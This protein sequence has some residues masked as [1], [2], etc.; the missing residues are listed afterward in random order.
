MSVSG[1]C[2][3]L[4]AQPRGPLNARPRKVRDG[5]NEKWRMETPFGRAKT[6]TPRPSPTHSPRPSERGPRRLGTNPAVVGLGERP[7]DPLGGVG[8]FD[9]VR[10]E[11]L[12]PRLLEE[13]AAVDVDRAGG[14]PPR[15]RD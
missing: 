6:R 13:I 7:I 4:P 9:V 10:G 1:G 14:G 5:R 12:T 2:N 15:V 11:P 3:G 8:G